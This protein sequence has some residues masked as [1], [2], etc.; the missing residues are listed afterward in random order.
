MAPRR[1]AAA[2]P[3]ED[4]PRLPGLQFDEPLTWRAGKAIPVGELLRRLEELQK[5]MMDM[6]QDETD[7][8]SLT[9][10]AK[11]LVHA[12][13]LHHK[14]KGVR[15]WTAA[16]LV[17]VLRICAPDAPFTPAQ[18]KVGLKL[19]AA[20]TPLTYEQDIFTL[21]VGSILPALSDPGH[22]YHN[23]HLYVLQSLAEVKSIVLL[24]D[25]DRADGLILQLFSSFFDIISGTA[26]SS[27]GEQLSKNAEY[28]MNQILVTMVDEVE[29]LP[30]P[31]VEII[32]V[33][34][35][36]AAPTAK[37]N[38]D[39]KADDKQTTLM[40][41]ELPAAYKMAEFLCNAC[42]E[43]MSRYISQYFNDVILDITSSGKLGDGD[44]RASMQVDSDDEDGTTGPSDSD[45]KEL[46]KAHRLLKE[47][48]RA[49]APVLQNVIPQLE[50][51]LS[52]ENIELRR[53]AT[54]T[55][56]DIVSGI[57][58]AG[59]P[60]P[61]VMD[62]A[63]YPQLTLNDDAQYNVSANILTT[64]LSP[65]SFSQTYP[66][67]YQKLLS[68]SND[69]SPV[70]RTAWTTAV[71]RI[72][73]TSAGGIGLSRE[74]EVALIKGLADKLNDGDERVRIAAVRAVGG[75]SFKDLVT[76]LADNGNVDKQ[77]SV[78]ASLA[79]RCRDKKHHVRVEAMTVLG[80]IWGVASGEVAAGNEAVTTLLGG[81][82]SRIFD[83]YYTNDKDI[84]VLL[85]HVM[86]EELLPLSYPPSKSRSAKKANGDSQQSQ[87]ANDDTFD[88]NKVRVER[89][90]VLVRLLTPKAKKAFLAMHGR[91]KLFKEVLTKFIEQCEEY[92]GGVMQGEEKKIKQRLDQMINWFC[93]SLPDAPR[94]S[95]DLWK[96][97]K[98]HD[99]RAYHLIRC[100]MEATADFKTVYKAIKE[101]TKRIEAAPGAPAGLLETMTPLLYRSGSIVYN[102][103]HLGAILEFSRN[104]ELGL[105][106]T[107]HEMLKEISER[108]P[109]IFKAQVK[110]LCKLLVSEA[111][112]ETKPNEI[113]SVKTLKACA[114]FARKYPEEIS[115]ERAFQQALIKF[116]KYSQPA[117]ASKYAVTVLLSTSD[118][119]EM[120]AK[121]LLKWAVQD[122]SFDE[123]FAVNKL[124]VISQITVLS[125]NVTDE[126]YDDILD[127]TAK[128]VLTNFRSKPDE[129]IGWVEDAALDLEGQAKCWAV[130]TLV[131]R[132]RVVPDEASAK[133]LEDP[134]CTLLNGLIEKEGDLL[135]TGETPKHHASRLRLLAAQQLLKL[136]TSKIFSDVVTSQ[137]FNR[138]A[139]VA[140]DSIFQ[141]RRGF[142]EKLQ[143]YLV[144]NRLPSRFY[145][146]IFL[147]AFEPETTFQLSAITWI[148]SR[149]KFFAD[150]QS[151]TME[152][153]MPRLLSLLAHHPDYSSE[154][155][156][157]A[158][159]AKYILFYVSNIANEDNAGLIFKYAERV[160]GARD[161]ISPAESD[162][163]YV[164]SDLAQAI[165]RKWELKKGWTTQ[166][167][168]GKVGLTRDIFSAMLDHATAQAVADKNF[169][170]EEMDDLLDGVVKVADRR[171]KAQPTKR[172]ASAD[173]GAPVAK[174]ARKSTEG[175]PTKSPAVKKIAKPKTPARKAKNPDD[176]EPSSSTAM[177]ASERRK[178]GRATASKKVY[179]DRDDSEDDEEMLEGVSK[180]EYEDGH[181]ESDHA[182]SADGSDAGSDDEEEQK[183]SAA[184]GPTSPSKTLDVEMSELGEDL[185]ESPKEATPAA[186]KES[187]TPLSDAKAT[188]EPQAEEEEGEVTP[189]PKGKENKKPAAA[190]SK[191]KAKA[192]LKSKAKPVVR[193]KSPIK[194]ARV[195]SVTKAL[196]TRG[197]ARGK[198][199]AKKAADDFDI[200]DDE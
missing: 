63:A 169:L 200:P 168:A 98:M 91:Q 96:F 40:F 140:Q 147:L 61:P 137:A 77:G 60:P 136:S 27:T 126:F 188:P 166:I 173:E 178:S 149:A 111:P 104:D 139:T 134:V 22:A 13:L 21:F 170:P 11:E 135:G 116:A 93:N 78:L 133:E 17:D 161:G 156:D 130:K 109:D 83:V 101:F 142:I 62:P 6:E 158:D 191:A 118:R 115:K 192:P 117:K 132:L 141:V 55:L 138:L 87:V 54:E 175:K 9:K 84:T 154:A 24:A 107:A 25:I 19:N 194:K 103:S 23:Q 58:A 33:Q 8:D 52:A 95:A 152:A 57:G 180:W 94:A 79:D 43:K 82:P 143:K 15:A 38:G 162:N 114:G 153:I 92:N 14:D 10:V 198:A 119:K 34:F 74:D 20:G 105:G 167:Y 2:A 41:K 35:L 76:K 39:A 148:K 174:K 177:T 12:N 42:P 26:K 183:P 65:Q 4:E 120:H 146:I 113:G 186:E 45:L 157:L 176:F 51:E 99:R 32:L 127:I 171:K 31:V 71:G 181:V 88:P 159:T 66:S 182:A 75:F 129:D 184:T 3:A 145:T 80:R 163:L 73:A 48:W 196:P 124:A 112:S 197:S 44:R 123:P 187:S 185:E 122:W 108:N 97:A 16:C 7:K 68:R 56:G 110:D 29:S 100:A 190:K 144:Q 102:Q 69:K 18:L 5:E 47:L 125:P 165:V 70:I 81:I 37:Q 67:V 72:I 160:K 195:V 30:A 89:L 85:D 28:M 199:K 86:F 155:A 50:A 46:N 151:T 1:G 53:L 49:A 59:P 193:A 189:K 179:A 64:P 131:N 106:A 172:K 164:L 36:R 121:D 90:L 150:K 128:Q